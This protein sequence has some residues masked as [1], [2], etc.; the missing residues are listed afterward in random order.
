MKLGEVSDSINSVSLNVELGFKTS[1]DIEQESRPILTFID[2]TYEMIDYG[3]RKQQIANLTISNV[4]NTDFI[5]LMEFLD[6]KQGTKIKIEEEYAGETLFTESNS[7]TTYYVYLVKYDNYGEDSFSQ[8]R[9]NFSVNLEIAFVGQNST[10][11]LNTVDTSLV[12]VLIKIDTVK[13]DYIVSAE[14]TAITHPA[15]IPESGDRWFDTDDNKLY[16]YDGSS[17][18]YLY[19]VAADDTDYGFLKGVF[20]WSLFTDCSQD[21]TSIPNT[22]SEDYISGYINR[23]SLRLPKQNVNIKNGPTI[24]YKNGFNFRASNN[25]KFWDYVSSNKISLYGSEV[26]LYLFNNNNGAKYLKKIATGINNNN[27]FGYTDYQFNCEP[28]LFDKKIRF[29]NE[30]TD[31]TQSR[32]LDI[33]DK[34]NKKPIYATYGRWDYARM[35]N[36]SIKSKEI[37]TTFTDLNNL[38]RTTTLIGATQILVGSVYTQIDIDNTGTNSYSFDATVWADIVANPDL[39]SIHVLTDT[40][41]A[42]D[43]EEKRGIYQALLL[44]AVFIL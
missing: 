34:F 16:K 3:S 28:I 32:Y 43:N 26:T 25:D 18:N 39:Y 12:D 36:I 31:S 6:E 40:N 13:A 9:N 7:F 4:S 38:T 37:E 27:Q 15:D 42:S 24:A 29:N 17:W 23:N 44:E 33:E 20:Y 35:Q 5:T 21:L 22:I 10:D 11:S 14:P 1:G 19:T 41:G 2:K 8:T 30:L